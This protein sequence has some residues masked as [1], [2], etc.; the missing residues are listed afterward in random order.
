MTSAQIQTKI[1]EN[2]ADFSNIIPEK[3]REVESDIL[4]YIV[5]KSKYFPVNV[6]FITNVNIP[7]TSGTVTSGGDITTATGTVNGILCE[8]DNAMPSTNYKVNI[9]IESL[10]TNSLDGTIK[11]PLFKKNSV[12]DFYLILHETDGENQNLKIH[13]EVISLD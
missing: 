12:N 1:N 7:V 5:D 6:G 2:L 13:F 3:H 9:S 8:M 10:G 4:Q 11:A